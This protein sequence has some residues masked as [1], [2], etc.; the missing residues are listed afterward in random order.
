MKMSTNVISVRPPFKK[1]L[2][3]NFRF[4]LTTLKLRLCHQTYPAEPK[5]SRCEQ[6]YIEIE[7]SYL[8]L[9][10]STYTLVM[11]HDYWESL[12]AWFEENI[13]KRYEYPVEPEPVAYTYVCRC[14]QC[15]GYKEGDVTYDAT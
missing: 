2:V 12:R 6:P 3:L 11:G 13:Q 14:A 9:I 1:Q 7:I 8:G 5:S 10:K 4:L 15:Q